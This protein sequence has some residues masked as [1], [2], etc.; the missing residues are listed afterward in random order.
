MGMFSVFML[1]QHWVYLL[2]ILVGI[3]PCL[4]LVSFYNWVGSRI[5]YGFGDPS[6]KLNGHQ[7]LN[8]FLQVE[9]VGFLLFVTCGVGWGKAL[10]LKNEHFPKP[11]LGRMAILLGSSLAMLACAVLSLGI[12][13]VLYHLNQESTLIHYLIWY[14]LYQGVLSLSFGLFQLLPYPNFPFYQLI[15]DFLPEKFQKVT[16]KHQNLLVFLLALLFWSGLCRTLFITLLTPLLRP[17]CALTNVPFDLVSYY[18]L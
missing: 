17:L 15:Y 5:A 12:S 8:P 18:F 4:L 6:A 10:P 9:P 16:R 7:S 13:S 3:L 11:F 1:T 2:S 14:F